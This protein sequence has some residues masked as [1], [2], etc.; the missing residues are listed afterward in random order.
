[1]L[2]QRLWAAAVQ[3]RAEALLVL[4]GVVQALF[5]EVRL[6]AGQLR[7]VAVVVVEAQLEAMPLVV[8]AVV[9]PPCLA[10]VVRTQ[11]LNKLQGVAHMLAAHSFAA[12][13]L[14][15]G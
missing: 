5:L 6:A 8:V 9:L 7:C 1:M 12:Y 2:P 13:G 10:D 14:P 15:E 11:V 3:L 4:R